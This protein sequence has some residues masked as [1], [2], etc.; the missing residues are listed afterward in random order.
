TQSLFRPFVASVVGSVPQLFGISVPGGGAATGGGAAG[1][2]SGTGG[3]GAATLGAVGAPCNT[4]LINFNGVCVGGA[5]ARCPPVWA[6]DPPWP[7]GYCSISGCSA[8]A[9]DGSNDTCPS[10]SSCAINYG[11]ANHCLAN[12]DFATQS[13]CRTGYLCERSL[14]GNFFQGQCFPRCTAASGQCPPGSRCDPSGH[15]CGNQGFKCCTTGSACNSGLSCNAGLG[16]YC[17]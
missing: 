7:G 9:M 1:G 17:F 14:G 4:S 10:G 6:D 8:N 16:G 12:C 11:G 13:G 2:S 15:C 3:G 5:A